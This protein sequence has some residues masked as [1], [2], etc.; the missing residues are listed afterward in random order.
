MSCG[1]V[2]ET[3]WI[4][5]QHSVPVEGMGASV[6]AEAVYE[7]VRGHCSDG[8]ASLDISTHSPQVKLWFAAGLFNL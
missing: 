4:H 2:Q 1:Q 3:V 8:E 7:S 5:S 6:E